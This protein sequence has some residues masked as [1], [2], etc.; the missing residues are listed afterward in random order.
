[1]IDCAHNG[2]LI[3]SS[4]NYVLSVALFCVCLCVWRGL[5]FWKWKASHE[6]TPVHPPEDMTAHQLSYR[7]EKAKWFLGLLGLPQVI[8]LINIHSSREWE[9]IS[10]ITFHDWQILLSEI[11]VR[12]TEC[13]VL[14]RNKDMLLFRTGNT[15][16]RQQFRDLPIKQIRCLFFLHSSAC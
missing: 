15:L 6:E 4:V 8:L 3:T 16:V 12:C 9:L 14:C 13:S 1:M 5:L 11:A 2:D 7:W 10:G